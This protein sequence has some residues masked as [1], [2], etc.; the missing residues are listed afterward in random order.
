MARR[1]SD[2]TVRTRHWT[3]STGV[4]RLWSTAFGCARK[5]HRL[6]SSQRMPQIVL[7]NTQSRAVDG[8][9]TLGRALTHR[10]HSQW[11][12]QPIPDDFPSTEESD[13]QDSAHRFSIAHRVSALR[14]T[15]P[16]VKI[17][18]ICPRRGDTN[19]PRRGPR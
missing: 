6:M 14:L 9:Y 8:W 7:T 17:P 11:Q 4:K 16:D 15:L 13:R 5:V 18:S 10:D 3:R 1:Q 2:Q 19:R 12:S